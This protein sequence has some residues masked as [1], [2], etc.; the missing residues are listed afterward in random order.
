MSALP[1]RDP[2]GLASIAQQ[3][4]DHAPWL[5]QTGTAAAAA[6]RLPTLRRTP[7]QARYSEVMETKQQE[8]HY[9]AFIYDNCA[10][11]ALT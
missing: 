2:T 5:S 8:S 11:L 1:G 6:R 9:G 10:A 7:T 4:K 3:L